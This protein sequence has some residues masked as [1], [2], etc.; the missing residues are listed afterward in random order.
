MER[1]EPTSVLPIVST[2]HAH[3]AA[4]VNL[5]RNKMMVPKYYHTKALGGLSTK[6][7]PRDAIVAIVIFYQSTRGLEYKTPPERRYRRNRD[8]L[9][10]HSGARV[11]NSPRETLSSQSRSFTKAL[12]GSSTKLPPRDAIVAIATF[13][14]STQGLEYK[15][16]PERRYRRNRDLLLKHSGARV[17]N[18]PRETLSSQSRSLNKALR[19]SS[20]KLPPRDAIVAITIFHQ[21]TR[22]LEYKISPK[23][24][25]SLTQPEA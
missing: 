9:S 11:Q 4:H 12:G 1:S 20:T 2:S 8:L 6:L 19:G 23:T 17:Q 18:S 13:Y 5:R 16:P 10:K 14:Q 22:G 15:A 24:S 25:S 3:L 7:P 21:N